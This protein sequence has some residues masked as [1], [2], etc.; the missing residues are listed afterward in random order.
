MRQGFY[1]NEE[2]CTGCRACQIACCDKNDLS[3]DVTF[4]Q[5]SSFETGAFPQARG[6]HYSLTCNH[7]ESPA[8]V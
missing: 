6:F 3:A 1:Y 2:N 5:V 7:C 8:C 4:R